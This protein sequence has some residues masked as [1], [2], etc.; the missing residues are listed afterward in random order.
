MMYTFYTDTVL[1][2]KQLTLLKYTD[3]GEKKK[4]NII[5]G[6]RHKWKD[7]ASLICD[8]PNKL[9]TLEQQYQS[10]PQECLRQIFID[11]FINKEPQDYSQD[12]S[13]LIEL[14]ED[15]DLKALAE[16]VKHAL[17]CT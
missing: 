6:A 13:G 12:W 1:S 15:V 14:L 17:S 4:L 3:K 9:S 2:L 11:D 8:D 5:E 10:K 16:R 7:V